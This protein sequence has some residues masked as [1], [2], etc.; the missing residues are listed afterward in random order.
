LGR[1]AVLMSTPTP[2]EIF[3]G[4]ER[5]LL[6]SS[7]S[8]DKR[9]LGCWLRFV[10]RKDGNVVFRFVYRDPQSRFWSSLFG[11]TGTLPSSS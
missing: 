4:R 5:Y 1:L 2:V 10:L 9:L 8:S 11:G 7:Y 6:D 3:Y